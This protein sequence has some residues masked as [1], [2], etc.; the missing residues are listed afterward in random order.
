MTS[1]RFSMPL[2]GLL[3]ALPAVTALA[4]NPALAQN[5]PPPGAQSCTGCHAS[6]AKNTGMAVIAG[7]PAV[8]ITLAMDQFRS[9]ARAATVMDRIA[10][11][12]TAEESKAIAAWFAQQK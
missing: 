8:E 2:L 11:G 12:V 10:K 3:I 6:L 4:Q 1:S 7:R 9:G 5:L